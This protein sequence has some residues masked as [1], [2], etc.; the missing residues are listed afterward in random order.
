MLNKIL[1]AEI[2][3]FTSW[4]REDIE[5]AYDIVS[6]AADKVYKDISDIEENEN[7]NYGDLC[8]HDKLPDETWEKVKVLNFEKNKEE[9]KNHKKIL[10]L[11]YKI[12]LLS[13]LSDAKN[14]V[15]SRLKI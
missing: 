14:S 4:T 13:N 3:E 8:N 5:N 1:N 6:A 12:E 11:I 9:S 7:L 15:I 2:K 10:F